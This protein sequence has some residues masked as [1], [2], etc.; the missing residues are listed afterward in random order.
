MFTKE[1]LEEI[2]KADA[3]IDAMEDTVTPESL[4]ISRELDKVAHKQA[5]SAGRLKSLTPEERAE[6]RKL[7]HREYMRDY[8]HRPYV[9]ERIR[10]YN[11]RPEVRERINAYQRKWRARKKRQEEFQP[12]LVAITAKEPK[13]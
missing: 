9:M 7:L 8:N 4:A 13:L 2:A 10:A 6:H 12:H 1:E 11:R 5:V 3:E